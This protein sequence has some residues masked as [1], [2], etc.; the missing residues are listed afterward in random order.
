MYI[1][2]INILI[3]SLVGAWGSRTLCIWSSCISSKSM[4]MLK[5]VLSI[6]IKARGSRLLTG[7]VKWRWRI[8]PIPHKI[9]ICV[10]ILLPDGDFSI[11]LWVTQV[12][13]STVWGSRNIIFS[14]M[15]L[16]ILFPCVRRACLINFQNNV[17]VFGGIALDYGF[18][19][20][21][22]WLSQKCI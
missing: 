21:K 9:V 16:S 19:S 11:D 12:L 1:R 22:C 5:P 18:S 17:I 6:S 20:M 15:F 8:F 14:F 10:V 7:L 2:G 4:Y 13:E 3:L